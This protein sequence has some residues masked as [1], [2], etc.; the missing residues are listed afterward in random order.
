M[1]IKKKDRLAEKLW[2][3]YL[4]SE[5]FD[6]REKIKTL[7]IEEEIYDG[8]NN[9]DEEEEYQENYTNILNILAILKKQKMLEKYCE[10]TI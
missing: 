5:N 7:D 10:K 4:D 2:K 6:E 1:M 9:K 8:N 3:I